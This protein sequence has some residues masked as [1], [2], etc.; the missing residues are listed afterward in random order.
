MQEGNG[1]YRL[2]PLLHAGELTATATSI[3]GK[4][5]DSAT[6]NPVIGA[7]LVALEQKDSAGVDRVRVSTLVNADGTF[8]L[9]PLPA[10]SYDVVIVG[11]RTD[12]VF[13]APAIVTG[14]AVGSTTGTVNLNLPGG[15]ATSSVSLSGMV[16]AQN[17]SMTGTAADVQLSALETVSAT[18]YTIPLPPTSTQNAATLAVETAPST[19]TLTC[20]A[21]T[22]CANF[23][24]A[25]A[26]GE[27]YIGTWTS[28]GATLMQSAALASYVV[29]GMAF[30][31]SSG[32]TADCSPSEVKS[33]VNTLTGAGP[34]SIAADT[35]AF[36]Q[37][38]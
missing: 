35:L 9:C 20:T 12:G 36:I 34:F 27:P 17:A 23:T 14:V 38:Q 37:C 29:D 4:V 33:S 7:V 21:G 22:D 1:Q 2:K 10:G 30:V 32:G 16:T 11:T 28:S 13:Y 15:T 18:V 26:S 19:N 5:L 3:N 25:L 8:V 31:P 6:G 24:M